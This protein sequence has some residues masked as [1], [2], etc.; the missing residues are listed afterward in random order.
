MKK[1]YIIDDD[2]DIVESISLVLEENG[3]RVAAQYDD[4]NVIENLSRYEPDLIILDVI[5]P[6]S[7]SA[8][9]E[10]AKAIKKDK[11]LYSIPIIMLSAVNEKDIYIGRFSDQDID[12]TWLPVEMFLDKPVQ[13]K[14]LL[15]KV[16]S[17]FE[18]KK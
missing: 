3:Y 12:P 10:I 1:V 9:F 5:F 15:K 2:R 13:P 8:G 6:E 4:E 7:S 18:N 17:I 14:E 16:K 11:K